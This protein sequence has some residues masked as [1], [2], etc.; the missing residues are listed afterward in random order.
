ML[1]EVAQGHALRQ[2][3]L[4]ERAGRSGDERLPAVAGRGH[5]GCAMDVKADV[6]VRPKGPLACV[7]AHAHANDG[8]VGPGL[9]GEALLG[10]DRSRDRSGSAR[11]DDEEAIPLG[12]HLHP[13][14]RREALTQDLLVAFEDRRPAL[15]TERGG[16]LRRPLDVRE[17]EGQ[18]PGR[19]VR[20]HRPPDRRR[21]T[22]GR[23]AAVRPAQRTGPTTRSGSGDEPARRR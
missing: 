9:G 20:A 16:Q 3:L 4:C 19:Q 1:P 23:R 8:V 5:A 13:A 11:E 10:G 6:V 15:V 18:R 21:R 2:A 14:A 7:E 22:G 17:Q 12:R